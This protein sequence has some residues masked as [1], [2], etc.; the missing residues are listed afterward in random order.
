MRSLSQPND[1]RRRQRQRPVAVG[2]HRTGYWRVVVQLD[3][4]G[5]ACATAAGCAGQCPACR[6]LNDIDSTIAKRR[7]DRCQRQLL[8]DDQELLLTGERCAVNVDRGDGHG[9]RTVGNQRGSGSRYVHG[10]ETTGVH[11]ALVLLPVK[12]DGDRGAFRNTH[13]RAANGDPVADIRQANGVIPFH[14]IDQKRAGGRV[15]GKTNVQRCRG[16]TRAVR[17]RHRKLL[18]TVAEAAEGRRWNLYR[19]AAICVNHAAERLAV[20]GKGHCCAWIGR[21]GAASQG[22]TVCQFG[23]IEHVITGNRINHHVRRRRVQANTP[24]NGGCVTGYIGHGHGIGDLSV[25]QRSQ[26]PGRQRHHP[27]ARR[28]TR[29]CRVACTVNV[30]GHLGGIRRDNI[31]SLVALHLRGIERI[32]TVDWLDGDFRRH[33]VHGERNGL[34]SVVACGIGNGHVERCRAI[35]QSRHRPGWQDNRPAAIGGNGTGVLLPVEGRHNRLPCA[36]DAGIA[37]HELIPLGFGKV[38]NA[39]PKRRIHHRL[40]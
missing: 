5:L 20:N 6:R 25:R 34:G 37:G 36:G 35:R 28:C 8:G 3:G 1:L 38:H 21:H 39:I 33:F 32:R 2:I 19:P 30:Y 13:R 14:R 4:D 26:R 16:V 9:C 29:Q 7:V 17:D 12:G 18:R 24:G 10:P 11:H 15:N 40:G 22:K 23:R 31:D 27:A